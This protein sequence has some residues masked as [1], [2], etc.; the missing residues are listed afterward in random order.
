MKGQIEE[1]TKLAVDD[2]N[3]R[4]T[5]ERLYYLFSDAPD[6]GSLIN[7]A[8]A[9]IRDR[10]FMPDYDRVTPVL[11]QA[12]A[13]EGTDPVSAVFGA[14]AE[15]VAR[16]GAL[17]A[18]RYTLVATNVPYLTRG[19]Q[20]E[21]LRAFLEAH[22]S[23]AKSDLATAF[24]E[25]CRAFLADGGA[26]SVVTPQNW[27][28]L[29]SYK[30]LRVRLL[31]E[32]RWD[33]VSRLGPGAFETI[34]GERVNIALTI[35]SDS[36]PRTD[37]LI[38]GIDASE[39]PDPFYK[40]AMLLDARLSMVRQSA[41][42]KNPDAR[43]TYEVVEHG[44]FL[45]AYSKGLVGIQTGDNPFYMRHWWEVAPKSDVWANCLTASTQ[46]DPNTGR[47]WVIRWERGNGKL[48]QDPQARI[49][50]LE[51][52]GKMG[53]AVS[54]AGQIKAFMYRGELYDQNA[55]VIVPK[56]Q[57]NL[58]AIWYFCTSVEFGR[59]I[60]RI[61]PKLNVTNATL[62]K[63]PFDLEYWQKVAEEA[64]PLP[65]PYSDDPTQWLFNGNPVNSTAP[66][67]VTVARLLG[68]HWPEQAEDNRDF[69]SDVDGIICIPPVTGEQPAAERLRS[70]LA[71]AY[72]NEWSLSLQEQLL[73]EAGSPSKSLEQ[74]L[75]DDFFA[76][77]CAL[78]RNRPFIWQIWDGRRD[79]FSALINYHGF[80]KS[81]LEKL[82]YT[83]LGWWIGVQRGTRDQGQAGADGRLTAALDLQK[84]LQLI[85]EGEA[86]HDIYVRWKP[87]H[88]QPAG[89][90]PGLD[91]GV[92]L[93]I[94]PF[95]TAGVLRR[96][97]T[98]NWKK[99]RGNNPDGSE[100]H[101]DLHYTIEEKTKAR[102]AAGL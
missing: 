17:L 3:L 10:M 38:T 82:T 54:R 75:R 46:P 4:L 61:D 1:W 62:V 16:A 58:P 97:F 94:R 40:A 70:L 98:I 44:E 20:D 11:A 101:N 50:G 67:Q 87:L 30:K 59:A 12:L 72:G 57:K 33:H 95:V 52:V 69:R 71:E 15:G 64:G 35:L 48:L 102:E 32:Q 74:W 13:K 78:F 29:G 24:V 88:S 2:V 43:F 86:P 37:H 19:K 22:H 6:L 90:N 79:G 9:P 99:D 68:Y 21:V 65:Q 28:F 36:V 7:P 8:V 53:V 14:V 56:E 23:D 47:Q 81:L 31:N 42:L 73:S 60:R 85:L 25:R 55:A 27:L 66:L 18:R 26:Y 83:Y 91:D 89:W 100:R 76:Q 93:N 49:Q 51:A 84:K 63:V 92:R 39:Q 96:K 41:L 34:G 5:L 80:N 45:S 77:H